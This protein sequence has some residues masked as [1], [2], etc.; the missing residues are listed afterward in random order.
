MQK[1]TLIANYKTD[2]AIFTD[3]IIK[4][5]PVSLHLI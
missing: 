1:Y 2:E 5:K 3:L 4:V